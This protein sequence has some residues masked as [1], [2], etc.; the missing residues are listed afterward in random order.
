MRVRILTAALIIFVVI[1]GGYYAF[2]QLI[3]SPD[4][5]V[6]APVYSTYNVERG[7]IAVGVDV[8]GPL[9]PSYGGSIQV[10]GG[11]GSMDS[12]GITSYLVDEV[13]VKPG[14]FVKQGQTLVRLDAPNLSVLIDNAREQLEMEEKSLASL[15][16]VS[17]E[18]IGQVNPDRGIIV[19][20]PIAGR[21]MDLQAKEGVEVK[22][23]EIIARIVNDSRFQVIAK[24]SPG[25]YQQL[26]EDDV[27]FLNFS[28]YFSEFI[29]AE[30][31]DI[32]PNP[33]PESSLDL[34]SDQAPNSQ[35][36]SY[37]FVYWVTLEGENP[38]LI[39][40]GMPVSI[41][42]LNKEQAKEK[43]LEPTTIRWARYNSQ[44]DKYVNEE[45]V[46]SQAESVVTEVFVHKMESVKEGQPLVSMAGQDVQDTIREKLDTIR[47]QRVELQ[48]LYSKE[49]LME[50]KAPIDGIVADL[51][52]QQGAT[53]QP[54]EWLGSIYQASDMRMWVQVDDVDILQVKQGAPVEVTVDAV[55]GKVFEGTVEQV[56]TM[57]KDHNGISRFEVMIKVAGGPELKPGMQ[58]KAYVKAGNAQNVIL[59]P[60]EA[61]FQE[62]GQNKVEILQ[63]D[64]IAKVVTVEL[65]LMNDRVAEVK[66][67]LT[68][69]QEV[70]TGSTADL[71]PSQKIQTDKLIPDSQDNEGENGAGGTG[72]ESQK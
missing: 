1:G 38:G 56:A 54:G 58:A 69:G 16:G 53:V 44:V 43:P 65:G 21:M 7:D 47:T 45:R 48:Q 14:D 35:K 46:L 4:Q 40:P 17:I 59:V 63:P 52:R 10:P 5:K 18:E 28:D 6:D 25:E 71:L 19:T 3:P 72:E 60:L 57:G 13:L 32:N 31:V 42:F 55:P 15:M 68:E 20:A 12:S 23:G 29:K 41:G 64:G 30:I 49:G 70:I 62:D 26:A 11:Y 36:E 61:V 24:L 67:G 51:N 39:R 22:Q 33:V 66:S 27:A 2:R 34:I 9:N 50:I 8:S 37:E